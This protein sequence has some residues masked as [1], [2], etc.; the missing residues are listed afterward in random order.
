MFCGD[1]AAAFGREGVGV[2]SWVG[3]VGM[4][5]DDGV[6]CAVRC[7]LCRYVYGNVVRLLILLGRRCLSDFCV[8]DLL[9]LEMHGIF[10]GAYCLRE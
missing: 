8:P 2:S 9:M 6:W 3:I 1:G 7:A 5:C 10:V 4:V